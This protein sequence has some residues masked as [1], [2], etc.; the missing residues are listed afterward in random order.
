[1]WHIYSVVIYTHVYMHQRQWVL[2]W[3]TA[4]MSVLQMYLCTFCS[5]SPFL[6][7]VIY[8]Q[9]RFHHARTLKIKSAFCL[10]TKPLYCQYKVH[11]FIYVVLF[12]LQNLCSVAPVSFC[13]LVWAT[14]CRPCWRASLHCQ[15]VQAG[16]QPV[17]PRRSTSWTWE[18]M[19][20]KEYAALYQKW[21]SSN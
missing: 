14:L 1:M 7:I 19:K 4:A 21:V 20:L 3:W 5:V 18:A 13:Q 6:V 2:L 15:A 8:L 11:A 16:A 9:E 10:C 17:S 12:S